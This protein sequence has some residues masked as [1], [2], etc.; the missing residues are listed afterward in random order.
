M[1]QLEFRGRLDRAI[2]AY[3]PMAERLFFHLLKGSRGF[4]AIP[5]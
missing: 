4:E 2:P 3:D 5:K 1:S